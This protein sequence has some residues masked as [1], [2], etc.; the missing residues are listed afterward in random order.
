MIE[1][2]QLTESEIILQHKAD[3]ENALKIL[4]KI[5]S[6]LSGGSNNW[7]EIVKARKGHI[8]NFVKSLKKREEEFEHFK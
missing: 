1:E 5:K 3:A 4:D 6:N 8:D 2:K 7:V